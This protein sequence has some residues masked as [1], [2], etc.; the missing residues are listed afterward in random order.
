MIEK[1]FEKETKIKK[2]VTSNQ[3]EQVPLQC[4]MLQCFRSEI[5]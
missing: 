3:F 5:L 1:V 4:A 2:N